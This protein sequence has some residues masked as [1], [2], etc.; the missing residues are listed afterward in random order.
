MKRVARVSPYTE[1]DQN[2]LLLLY[3]HYLLRYVKEKQDKRAYEV[4][5]EVLR[6][7]L[8][9]WSYAYLF[10]DY[11]DDLEFLRKLKW[12]SFMLSFWYALGGA[13]LNTDFI[14][15]SCEEEY[16]EP[17]LY[18]TY[19]TTEFR[20]FLAFLIF[21]DADYGGGF[22]PDSVDIFVKLKDIFKFL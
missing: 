16:K 1:A 7:N 20:S 11:L 12:L 10:D 9:I 14:V 3:Y 2:L 19:Y 18:L 5:K 15:N 8:S 17:I 4:I 6:K 13:R 22:Y 21:P